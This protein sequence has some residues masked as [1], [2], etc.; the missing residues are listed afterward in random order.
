MKYDISN[1][2][3]II[4]NIKVRV[5]EKRIDTWLNKIKLITIFNSSFF[6]IQRLHIYFFYWLSNIFFF[7][8]TLWLGCYC[9]SVKSIV[10]FTYKWKKKKKI[11][12]KRKLNGKLCSV[13]FFIYQFCCCLM[14]PFGSNNK[15]NRI[16][17]N[18]RSHVMHLLYK[19][20]IHTITNWIENALVI[21]WTPYTYALLADVYVCAVPLK[22]TKMKWKERKWIKRNRRFRKLYDVHTRSHTIHSKCV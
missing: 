8:N 1:F 14:K 12:K 15:N 18:W 3:Y 9:R 2:A 19:K 20:I 13:G 21:Y 17:G 6:F 4:K 5:E 16:D 11:G 10:V 7:P 22:Q